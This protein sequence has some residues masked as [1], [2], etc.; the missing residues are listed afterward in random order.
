[1]TMTDSALADFL[2]DENLA[3]GR[4][5]RPSA[6]GASVTTVNPTPATVR[7][8][9]RTAYQPRSARTMAPASA[10]RLATPKQKDYLRSL[11]GAAAPS[12]ALDALRAR[13]NGI[14]PSRLTAADASRAID[15]AKALPRATTPA[16]APTAPVVPDGRYAIDG[17]DGATRFYRVNTPTEGRWAG[18]TFVEVQASDEHYPLRDAAA[19]QAILATIA[20]DRMGAL[21]RYG[22]ELGHCGVCG[23]TLTDE[24]SRARGIGPICFAAL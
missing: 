19:R 8:I 9:G 5:L 15:E 20:A 4:A 11:L 10:P 12:A 3:A 23:R 21:A 16:A 13:L 2:S 14:G 1:M 18:R 17:P 7:T 6:F 22:H 24:E